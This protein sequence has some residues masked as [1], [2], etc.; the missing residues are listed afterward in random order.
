MEA[1]K[2]GGMDKIGPYLDNRLNNMQDIKTIDVK[3]T[4]AEEKLG[5][6]EEEAKE[7][8]DQEIERR[9]NA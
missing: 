2:E 3:L 5:V 8:L 6:S 1:F 4:E 7:R 9:A